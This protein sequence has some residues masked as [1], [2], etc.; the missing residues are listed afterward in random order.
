MTATS[1]VTGSL[2]AIAVTCGAAILLSLAMVGVSGLGRSRALR[3]ELAQLTEREGL[4]AAPAALA[5]S[6]RH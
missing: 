6:N 3:R 5:G 4:V 2:I 1:L